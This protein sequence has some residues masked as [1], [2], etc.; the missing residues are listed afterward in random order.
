MFVVVW[1]N[2]AVD[3]LTKKEVDRMANAFSQ[4]EG[5]C[6]LN[7]KEPLANQKDLHLL[8]FLVAQWKMEHRKINT[9]HKKE[10]DF[11]QGWKV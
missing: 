6:K 10:A 8:D 1:T 3:W 11:L 2:G 5:A 9:G 4:M 7:E